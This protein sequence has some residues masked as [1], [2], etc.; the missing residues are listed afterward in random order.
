MSKNDRYSA[1]IE[2]TYPNPSPELAEHIKAGKA[3]TEAGK[4]A[5]TDEGV[6]S[7]LAAMAAVSETWNRLSPELQAELIA[8][9]ATL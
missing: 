5:N 6:D 1:A 2:A 4:S 9:S 3:F 7:F 8:L